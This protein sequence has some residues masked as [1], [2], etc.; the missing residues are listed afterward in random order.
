MS[1]HQLWKSYLPLGLAFLSSA[2]SA[3]TRSRVES[4]A[5]SPALALQDSA[6]DKP[7]AQAAGAQADESIGSLRNA[8][9]AFPTNG[10]PVPLTFLAGDVTPEELAAIA[11]L[12]PNV[13]ILSGLSREQALAHAAEAD[14]C[15]ARFITPVFLAEA[16][17]L[18]WAQAMSAGVDRYLELEYLVSEDRIVLTNM[19]GVHGPAISDHVFAMLL[20]LTRD[21]RFHLANQATGTWGRD[22]AAERHP[23]VLQG[24]TMLVVG[25]GGIGGEV[26]QRAQGFGMHVIATRRSD[27]P[28][29]AYLEYV[30]KPAELLTLLPRAD[31]VVV[32]TPLTAETEHLFNRAAFAAMKPG[33]YF[34]NIARGRVVETDA[35][36][37]AL[38]DKK[39]AG[40]CLDVTDP[41]PLPPQHPLWKMENVVITP[42][43][44]SDGEL[45]DQRAKQ[46][47]HENLRR[48]AAGLPLLNVV[49]KHAGY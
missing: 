34:V 21:L 9:V 45:T 15:D 12:A 20:S 14:A 49:D 26:A 48:F 40:A 8:R 19:Q 10:K 39:L 13:R 43:V 41:E 6:A 25:L 24:R 27:T 18:V 28:S 16:N 38:R 36:F 46:L 2:C 35:L 4:A 5:L 44:A 33:A 23:I 37:E 3:P 29:P 11:K 42:H 17:K 22:A 31:V 47:F 30:G 1:H 32:C 7:P